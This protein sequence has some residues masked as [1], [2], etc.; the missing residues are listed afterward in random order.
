MR[1]RLAVIQRR[2]EARWQNLDIKAGSSFA[3]FLL[4]IIKFSAPLHLYLT[5]LMANLP[6]SLPEK[7]RDRHPTWPTPST[8]NVSPRSQNLLKTLASMPSF[9]R[10]AHSPG[11]QVVYTEPKLQPSQTNH[12]SRS[13]TP[14][15]E[16]DQWDATQRHYWK[17][18]IEKRF[19]ALRPGQ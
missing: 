19:V 9:G 12:V 1:N 14:P 18:W 16:W 5:T 17:V 3:A 2:L 11:G 13:T 15:A 7:N 10:L 4:L 8:T 6:P